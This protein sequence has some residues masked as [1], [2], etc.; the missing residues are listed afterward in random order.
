MPELMAKLREFSSKIP[1]DPMQRDF[2]KLQRQ[3]NGSYNDGDLAE[4]LS[5]SIEDVACAFGPNNVPAIMRSIEILG[6]EQARA[7]NVG[8]LNDFRK[9]FGLKPHEKFEDISSDPEVADTLRHLYDHVD[10]VELYP[11]VVVE[12]AKETRVPGSGLA[13]TFTIS[14]AILSDAVTL[15][16]SDRFYTVDYVGPTSF[17]MFRSRSHQLTTVSRR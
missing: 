15:A 13:T 12:D 17:R 3:E 14:R 4:I 10:R 1:A 5:D 16:R 6:I 7:W 11:G 8:S 2:A 9:F